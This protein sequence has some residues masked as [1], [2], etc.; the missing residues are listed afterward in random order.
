MDVQNS[1]SS[2]VQQLMIEHKNSVEIWK[3]FTDALNSTKESVV[4]NIEDDSGNI[5]RIQIPSFGWLK[6]QVERLDNNV[7]NLSGLNNSSAV[8]RNP[9]GTFSQIILNTL[10]REAPS[11][12]T[13]AS[14]TSFDFK[15]NWF[16]E[17]FLNPLIYVNF[18]LTGQIDT[19]TDKAIVRRYILNIATDDELDYFNVN[20]DGRNDIDIDL[21]EEDLTQQ[22]LQY[23]TDEEVRTI[24][25]QENIFFGSF[26]VIKIFDDTI[27]EIADITSE[28]KRKKKYK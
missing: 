18:E 9:D 21:L 14:P 13:L 5:D 3:K 19:R 15:N 16:F 4:V 2:F 17:N 26:D 8:N 1:L 25:Y 27:D 20:Y 6:A 23:F 10:D 28:T 11:L 7:Q 24:P 12:T 22:R